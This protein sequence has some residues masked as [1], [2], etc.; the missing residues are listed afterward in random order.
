MVENRNIEDEFEVVVENGITI[1]RKKNYNKIVEEDL[2]K[3]SVPEAPVPSSEDDINWIRMERTKK[4]E[5]T[6][7]TQLPDVPEATR[8]KWSSYRQALRDITNTYTSMIDVVW[9]DKPE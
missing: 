6:D 2:K 3:D 1:H 5:E 4:L 8:L 9:P 7:W